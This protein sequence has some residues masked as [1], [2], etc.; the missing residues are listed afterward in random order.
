MRIKINAS[1]DAKGR[2]FQDAVIEQMTK[3]LIRF[4]N[5]IRAWMSQLPMRMVRAAASTN[6]AA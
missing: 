5:R 6:S 3:T 4:S 2:H 1:A